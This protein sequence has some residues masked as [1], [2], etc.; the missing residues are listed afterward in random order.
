MKFQPGDQ[1]SVN[2]GPNVVDST[3]GQ[4]F[5]FPAVVTHGPV[6]GNNG[7]DLYCTLGV[8]PAAYPFD[9]TYHFADDLLPASDPHPELDRRY[10]AFRAWAHPD[11]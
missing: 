10:Q 5:R 4:S 7:R 1:V 9:Q 3:T 2:S 6:A 11:R 8:G